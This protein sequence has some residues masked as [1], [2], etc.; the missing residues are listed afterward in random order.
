MNKRADT[1]KNAGSPLWHI[2]EHVSAFVGSLQKNAL[3]GHCVPVLLTAPYGT[4]RFRAEG[5]PWAVCQSALVPVGCRYEFDMAGDPL[6]VIY[7]DPACAGAEALSSLV[8]GDEAGGAMVG[9]VGHI[10][11]LRQLY[12]DA[13]SHAWAGE[14]LTDLVRFGE[15]RARRHLDPRI[16]RAAAQIQSCAAAN[17]PVKTVALGV[18]LSPS[19]FQHLFTAEAGVPFR[20]YRAWRRLLLAIEEIAS[21]ATYTAAA[22]AAG[23]ADQSHFAREFRRSFGASASAG[24]F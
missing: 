16:A 5:G 19:H 22:H 24:S 15:T 4:F 21:G 2:G 7:L 13:N 9:S 20:R 1:T 23:Y 14:A 3:H 12:E 11:L 8:A 17:I 18:G 10:T 6:S